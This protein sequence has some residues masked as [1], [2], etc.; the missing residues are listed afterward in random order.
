[1]SSISIPTASTPTPASTLRPKGLILI[2]SHPCR[3]LT[4]THSKPRKHGH[5]K[6]TLLAEDLFTSKKYED[7]FPAHA[8][9]EVPSVSRISYQLLNLEDGEERF[10]SLMEIG[11]K[12]D[13]SARED[14][15]CPDGVMGEKL[16]RLVGEGKEVEIVVLGCM[17]MERVIEVSEV[18][19]V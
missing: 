11:G 7:S 8:I 6:I 1:M 19:E 9:I 16:R 2:H 15:K 5:A 13:G 14:V 4:L 18:K 17:G 10:M 3:I 12:S